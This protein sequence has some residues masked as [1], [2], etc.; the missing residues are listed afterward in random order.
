MNLSLNC[1][2]RQTDQAVFGVTSCRSARKY[3]GR[4]A[5]L[6]HT[7][8]PATS[9]PFHSEVYRQGS[10][11]PGSRAASALHPRWTLLAN[12]DSIRLPLFSFGHGL[13]IPSNSTRL[14]FLHGPSLG[15]ANPSLVIHG[16][17]L[18]IIR[19]S[20]FIC[21]VDIYN[22]S[23]FWMCVPPAAED[24][25]IALCTEGGGTT[26]TEPCIPPCTPKTPYRRPNPTM[27]FHVGTH[28]LFSATF[29]A[30]GELP[31]LYEI[32]RAP[33]AVG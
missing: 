22:K 25:F 29:G 33:G 32:L 6:Q 5:P 24:G 1:P 30:L 15:L 26:F 16:S 4:F 7:A 14:P 28:V 8:S 19:E 18:T 3:T 17:S 11:T 10:Q 27:Q 2:H 23:E 31:S 13:G 21:S 9:I 12:L 20:P